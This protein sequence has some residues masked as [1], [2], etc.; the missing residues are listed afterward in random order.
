MEEEDVVEEEYNDHDLGEFLKS[1]EGKSGIY[2]ISPYFEESQPDYLYPVKVGMSKHRQ[3]QAGHPDVRKRKPYGG[4]GRRLDS[5]LLCYVQGFYVYAV[6]ECAK[7]NVYETEKFFHQYFTSKN[8]KVENQHSHR[9]EWFML[10]R[11]DIY[12]TINAFKEQYP[13]TIKSG[14]LFQPVPHFVDTNGRLASNPKKSLPTEEKV[15]LQSYM[16]KDEVPATIKKKRP[17]P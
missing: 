8:F 3:G 16:E 6:L 4:L 11:K 17:L 10:T 14:T 7:E 5:Y 15:Q 1:W 2:F 12:T 13:Q 9:E